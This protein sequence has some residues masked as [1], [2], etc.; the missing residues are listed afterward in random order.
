MGKKKHTAKTGTAALQILSEAGVEFELLEYDADAHSARGFALDTAQKLALDPAE[1]FKTLLATVHGGS[2]S[3]RHADHPVIAVVPANCTLNLKRL[4]AAAGGKKAE[5]MPRDKAQILTGYVAGGISP[6][7][8][9]TP[10]PVFID[11]RAKLQ[12]T[13]LVSAGKRG[14]SVRISPEKLAELCRGQFADLADP[15]GGGH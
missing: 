9:K 2:E 12:T 11:E 4:A 3:T 14:N 7:G 13:I 15:L 5:M 1:I 8:T 10:L 6:L